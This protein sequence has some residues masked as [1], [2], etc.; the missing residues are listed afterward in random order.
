[1]ASVVADKEKNGTTNA[2]RKESEQTI[3]QTDNWQ[4]TPPTANGDIPLS[5]RLAEQNKHH[6]VGVNPHLKKPPGPPPSTTG[7]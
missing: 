2:I 3:H 5:S 1:M 7:H 6:N 4:A